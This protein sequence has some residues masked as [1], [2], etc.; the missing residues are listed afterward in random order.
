MKFRIYYTLP[1]GVEDYVV[2]AG[3]TLEEIKEKADAEVAKRGGTNPWSED[4]SQ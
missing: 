1:D 4:V 3:E 2:V